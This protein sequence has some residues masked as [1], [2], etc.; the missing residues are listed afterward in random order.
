MVTD[1]GEGK[2]NSNLL[3]SGYKTDFVS[4][5]V[6]VVGLVNTYTPWYGVTVKLFVN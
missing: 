4:H 3:N 6:C 1:L 2:L 5:P